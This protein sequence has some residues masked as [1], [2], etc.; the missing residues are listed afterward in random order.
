MSP[1][2]VQ[3]IIVVWAVAATFAAVA[4]LGVGSCG[5]RS[6]LVELRRYEPSACQTE[7]SQCF[8]PVAPD[9]LVGGCAECANTGPC[10]AVDTRCSKNQDC[11]DLAQCV[12]SCHGPDASGDCTPPDCHPECADACKLVHPAG[13]RDYEAYLSCLFCDQCRSACY[14]TGDYLRFGTLDCDTVN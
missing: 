14:E 3:R 9:D 10:A 6:S 12:S 8:K 11:S 7:F 2:R 1:N 13:V 5:G 4:G